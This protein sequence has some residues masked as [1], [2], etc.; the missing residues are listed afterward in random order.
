MERK[1][2]ER[3][4]DVSAE[5][6]VA[7]WGREWIVLDKSTYSQLGM[8]HPS[9]LVATISAMQRIERGDYN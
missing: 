1:D 2:F 3:V 5:L 9:K 8:P 6:A 7:R 4:Y